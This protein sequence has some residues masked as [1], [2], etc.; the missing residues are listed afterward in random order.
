MSIS[1]NFRACCETES[2]TFVYRK[3]KKHKN[4]VAYKERLLVPGLGGVSSA[5]V[6][7]NHCVSEL[8]L[9]ERNGESFYPF[10][11]FRLLCSVGQDV[12]HSSWTPRLSQDGLGAGEC[13]STGSDMDSLL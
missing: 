5:L 4:A 1:R 12:S 11:L 9:G 2:P 13:P 6:T 3:E 10:A 7:W 8:P